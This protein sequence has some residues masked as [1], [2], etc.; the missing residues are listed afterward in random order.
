M[1]QQLAQMLAYGGGGYGSGQTP[2][3]PLAIRLSQQNIT[4]PWQLGGNLAMIA[5]E[6]YRKGRDQENSASSL[7]E[8]LAG[9]QTT[10]TTMGAGGSHPGGGVT[11]AQPN[12]E[13]D[14]IKQMLMDNPQMTPY[15]QAQAFEKQFPGM[16]GDEPNLVEGYDPATGEY[17]LMPEA[18][19]VVTRGPEK[20]AGGNWAQGSNGTWYRTDENGNLQTQGGPSGGVDPLFAVGPMQAISNNETGGSPNA[21]EMTSPKG[22]A[23]Q[24]QIM[25]ATGREIAQQLGDKHALSLDDFEFERYLRDPAVNK[26]YGEFYYN[27][28]LEK[29]GTP[30]LAAAAY[31]AGPGAVGNALQAAGGNTQQA[32]SQLPAETQDY[33]QKFNAQTGGGDT[34][35]YPGNPGELSDK[36][37]EANARWLESYFSAH[38]NE[39]PNAKQKA[40]M[41]TYLRAK[42]TDFEAQL[43]RYNELDA[44][45]SADPK[46]LTQ[47]EKTERKALRKKLNLGSNYTG[48]ETQSRYLTG[49]QAIDNANAQLDGLLANGYRPDGMAQFLSG[50]QGTGEDLFAS[51]AN[52]GMSPEDQIFFQLLYQISD[53]ANRPVSGAAITAEDLKNTYRQYIP[54]AADDERTI[55][56]KRNALYARSNSFYTAAGIDAETR[57]E[58]RS[59]AAGMEAPPL[60][61]GA[62]IGGGGAKGKLAAPEADPA[63]FPEG[64]VYEGPE[65]KFVIQN[66]Q[67]WATD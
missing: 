13:Y 65:G 60:P 45:H 53:G 14:R 24:Y 58:M 64:S 36:E 54:M 66:G 25:P 20:K 17:K 11:T 51:I 42:S 7:A 59:E 38:T 21:A 61:Q 12:P 40:Y 57:D 31:N 22:A 33:V 44:K 23:G 3:S 27:Q 2:I 19:G 28:Q 48:N 37:N 5:A 9:G 10:S 41:E 43:A 29:F 26:Q 34:P 55:Q 39:Q 6:Q 16:F 50:M 63:Q 56:R 18:A 8:M 15:F 46:S 32:L 35:P 47:A 30:E 4:S 62:A 52:S 49:A 1:N 67:W